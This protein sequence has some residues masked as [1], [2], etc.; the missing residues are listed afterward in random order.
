[1][2]LAYSGQ[3]LIG[4]WSLQLSRPGG[5]SIESPHT[6]LMGTKDLTPVLVKGPVEYSKQCGMQV[7][8]S[9]DS[10]LTE[11][12]YHHFYNSQ[13]NLLHGYPLEDPHRTLL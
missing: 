11:S 9:T 6:Q 5:G 13:S 10:L 3:L 7:E 8:W 1:M 12:T 2:F 4:C